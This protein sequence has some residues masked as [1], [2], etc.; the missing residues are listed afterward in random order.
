[1]LPGVSL[2]GSLGILDAPSCGLLRSSLDGAL[3]ERIGT[4]NSIDA[5][6]A[7][8]AFPGGSLSATNALLSV[9]LLG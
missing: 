9:S 4:L 7:R 6:L 8:Y 1:M 2:G 3:G 5:S